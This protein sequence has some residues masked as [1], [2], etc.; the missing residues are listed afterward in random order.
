MIQLSTFEQ[1]QK[2]HETGQLDQAKLIYDQ[3]IAQ[4]ERLS[5]SWNF[6]GLIH[7]QKQEFGDALTSW[8]KAVA[9][10]SNYV[11]PLLNS[12]YIFLGQGKVADALAI[13]KRAHQLA[14]NKVEV[15]LQYVRSLI[16]SHSYEQALKF[17][18]EAPLKDVDQIDVKLLLCT[19]CDQLGDFKAAE[20]ALEQAQKLNP[21]HPQI[22]V[23]RARHLTRNLAY[24]QAKNEIEQALKQYPDYPPLLIAYGKILFINKDLEKAITKLQLGLKNSPLEWEGWI[25]LGDAL[26]EIGQFKDAIKAFEAASAIHP[27]HVGAKQKL[28]KALARFV[29]PWHAEM[30]ADTE[31]NKAYRMAIEELVNDEST[32]LEIGTGSGILSILAAKAGANHVY[33]F[34]QMPELADVSQKN[35]KLNGVEDKVTIWNQPSS[36]FSADKLDQKATILL[37]EIFDAGLLGEHALPSFR[38]ALSNL[39]DPSCIVIPQRAQVI[40][41]LVN[42]PGLSSVNPTKELE[43]VILTEFDRFR[44]PVEYQSIHLAKHIYTPCSEPFPVLDVD[45]KNLW[46]PIPYDASM[47]TSVEVEVTSDKPIHAVAFWFDLDLTE[48][49]S[50]S[51]HPDRKDNHWGQAVFFLPSHASFEVGKKVTL[52]VLYNDTFM[53]FDELR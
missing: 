41:Q 44:I 14:P 20:T 50:L 34:E 52:P 31:R 23:E 11:D 12:S 7:Y 17:L 13:L 24:E 19:V 35:A 9:L 8:Q 46:D 21:A 6:V 10:D 42:L 51:N 28:A 3:L 29:P 33:G 45:F 37:A 43:G 47:E 26:M 22:T 49:V 38:H 4:G 36:S 15:V 5:E 1:A 25:S 18:T 40:G 2:L 39:C 27:T 16:H 32:V 48:S 30:L 53:W